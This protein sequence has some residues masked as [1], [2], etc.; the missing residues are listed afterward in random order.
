METF[1]KVGTR[2]AIAT[3]AASLRWLRVMGGAA[4]ARTQSVGT[5]WLT[6]TLLDP[7]TPSRSDAF[8]FGRR[9]AST[10][11]AGAGW[12]GQA[13]PELDPADLVLAELEAPAAASPR[14]GSFGEFYAEARTRPYVALA[15]FLD[16]DE[17]ALLNRACDVIAEGKFDSPQPG[18]C[19]GVARI[20]GDLWGGNIVWAAHG[21]GT[22]GTLIDPCA[23]GGHAETDLAELA[24]FGSEHLESTIAGYQEVSVLADGWRERIPLHQFHMLLVHVVLYQGNYVRRA[25]EVA[26]QLSA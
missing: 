21:N 13:P 19:H 23:H 25:L 6:T 14:W 7:A 16:G 20:H 17:S 9:L 10:H 3:E 11:A 1:H 18:M 22:T 24:L 2:R 12:W 26:R 8:D 5:T 15:S 4:V